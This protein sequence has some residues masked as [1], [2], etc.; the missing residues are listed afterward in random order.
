MVLSTSISRACACVK[1]A[2]R[3]GL[4]YVN[5]RIRNFSGNMCLFECARDI[6]RCGTC[7]SSVCVC[8]SAA[9]IKP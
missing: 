7:K 3:K 5:V 4:K 1:Q 8:F 9:V 6:D 2:V